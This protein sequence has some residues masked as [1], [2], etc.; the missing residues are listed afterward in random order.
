VNLQ[1]GLEPNGCVVV[2]GHLGEGLENKIV[3]QALLSF[4]GKDYL[5]TPR[6]PLVKR[7]SPCPNGVT[8]PTDVEDSMIGNQ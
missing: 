3:S 4:V 2:G 8:G 6:S 7:G 1:A 5:Y